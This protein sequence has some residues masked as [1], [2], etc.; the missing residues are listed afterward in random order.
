MQTNKAYSQEPIKS[1]LNYYLGHCPQG[2]TDVKGYY[3]VV[4]PNVY[5]KI[6]M[7]CYSNMNVVVFN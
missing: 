1:Y 2:V 4:Y 6:D 5:P 7:H 3:R